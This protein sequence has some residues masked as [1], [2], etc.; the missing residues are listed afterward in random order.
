[1]RIP[2]LDYARQERARFPSTHTLERTAAK[3]R[4]VVDLSSID[5]I[6][7]HGMY[8]VP[9]G[10][11]AHHLFVTS[12]MPYAITAHGGDI[13]GTMGYQ[14][15]RYAEVLDG[16]GAVAYVSNALRERAHELGAKGYNATVIPNG[17]DCELFTP[18]EPTS[19]AAS[20][21]L[22]SRVA[23]VGNLIPVKGADRLP[24]IFRGIANRRP[25]TSFVIAGDGPLRS[26]IEYAMKGLRVE[27]LGSV[28]QE[29]VAQVLRGA[30]LAVLPSRSE[31]WPCVVLEAHASGTSMIGSDAGGTA[32]AIGDAR[33][34]VPQGDDFI[35]R[36]VETSIR[37]LGGV[38]GPRDLRARALDFSWQTIAMRETEMLL[39][40]SQ[41][42][43]ETH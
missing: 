17:V 20:A 40:I 6:H 5:V 4:H 12:G 16:A 2:S 22:G 42:P 21:D 3:L 33:F 28:P 25:N 19:V 35:E 13:N 11:L 31:G 39:R 8:L 10:A 41:M 29:E 30:D 9:A 24:E 43:S 26:E 36:F 15:E 23:F 14:P 7:A 18:P 38:V 27:F 1:V 37:V 34:V 32:E